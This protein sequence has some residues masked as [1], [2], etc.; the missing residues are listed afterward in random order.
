VRIDGDSLLRLDF[1]TLTLHAGGRIFPIET[2]SLFLL[3]DLPCCCCFCWSPCLS[4]GP[5]AVGPVRKPPWSIW[6]NGAPAKSGQGR[7]RR[8]ISHH[9]QRLLLH[10]IYLL[11]A[12]LVAPTWSGISF[13]VRFFS[14]NC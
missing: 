13:P 8:F 7:R 12:L 3:L 2:L 10:L 1:A 9:G 6:L 11:L 5:G 14:H 4:A